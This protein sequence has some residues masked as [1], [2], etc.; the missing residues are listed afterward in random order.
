MAEINIKTH[1]RKGKNG[2]T[3]TVKG[4]TR[5]VGRKG[6]K[7]PKEKSEVSPGD[8]FKA[9]ADEKK[10]IYNGPK[11]TEKETAAWDIA[12]RKNL[13]RSVGRDRQLDGKNNKRASRISSSHITTIKN[14]LSEKG[15]T[16]IFNRVEDKIA[17]FVGKYSGK[18]YKKML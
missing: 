5:R 8:E 14:P 13:N 7:S 1:T 18:K 2:K 6:I 16:S 3:V 10:Q 11:M 15:S 9:K 17:K 4:Y 12:A